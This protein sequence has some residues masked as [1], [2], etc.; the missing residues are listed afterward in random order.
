MGSELLF[1]ICSLC[2]IRFAKVNTS[3]LNK[4]VKFGKKTF[5]RAVLYG[6]LSYF[7]SALA[8]DFSENAVYI[9]QYPLALNTFCPSFTTND[10]G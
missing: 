4:Q 10:F 9:L 5:E 2:S 7:L 8:L 3:Q 1:L 6:F